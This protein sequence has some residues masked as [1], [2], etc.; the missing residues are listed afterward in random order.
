[1]M[2]QRINETAEA[3]ANEFIAKQSMSTSSSDDTQDNLPSSRVSKDQARLVYKF[4]NTPHDLLVAGMSQMQPNQLSQ[5]YRKL[6]I[7][8]HPDKNHHP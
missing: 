6:A 7:Q 2:E 5:F 1:M 8:L 4:L 3:L